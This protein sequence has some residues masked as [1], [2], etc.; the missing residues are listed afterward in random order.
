MPTRQSD[1]TTEFTDA[2]TIQGIET[3]IE[4]ISLSVIGIDGALDMPIPDRQEVLKRAR[5]IKRD[6]RMIERLL[7]TA[8]QN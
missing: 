8:A 6:A 2:N 1:L 4:R 3:S 5:S 7:E